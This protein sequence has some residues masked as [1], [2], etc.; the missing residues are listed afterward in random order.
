MIVT[1]AAA[2]AITCPLL[3][4]PCAASHCMAWRWLDRAPDPDGLEFRRQTRWPE[5]DFDD[6]TLKKLAKSKKELPR[7]ADLPADW[8]WD[9]P[10]WETDDDGD[11]LFEGACWDEPAEAPAKRLA[12]AVAARRGFCGQFGEPKLEE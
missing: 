7:P 3:K 2:T 6:A 8:V 5:E 1:A 9:P 12:D 11:E 10:K 4:K